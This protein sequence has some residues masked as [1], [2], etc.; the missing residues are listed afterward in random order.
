MHEY[1]IYSCNRKYKS[2]KK[3]DQNY[4]YFYTSQRIFIIYFLILDTLTHLLSLFSSSLSLFIKGKLYI[5]P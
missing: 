3:K 2:L 4:K 5:L 1:Y